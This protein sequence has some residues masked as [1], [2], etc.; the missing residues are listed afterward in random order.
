V[1]HR[2]HRPSVATVAV[3]AVA[4]TFRGLFSSNGLSS[5][6]MGAQLGV[7]AAAAICPRH[8]SSS[9][10]VGVPSAT[11]GNQLVAGLVGDY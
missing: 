6:A 5:V 7:G 2:A 10:V 3:G 8:S 9:V 11:V 4:R 1:L